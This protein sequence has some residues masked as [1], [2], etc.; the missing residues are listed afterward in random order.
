MRKNPLIITPIDEWIIESNQKLVKLT[1]VKNLFQNVEIGIILTAKP[2]D[3]DF[4]YLKQELKRDIK[5]WRLTIK[6]L[7][8]IKL[9]GLYYNDEKVEITNFF[10]DP[11][12]INCLDLHLN[13]MKQFKINYNDCNYCIIKKY[14]DY[15]KIY[16]YRMGFKFKKKF[17]L[18]V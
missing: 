13:D 9:N 15:L 6:I 7:R 8:A 18:E 16:S 2:K 1:N 10:S 3:I 12:I 5:R 17:F 4:Y 11:N 14:D